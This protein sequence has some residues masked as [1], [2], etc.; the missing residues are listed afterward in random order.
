MLWF[1]WFGF[2]A[3]SA[4]AASETAV[5]AFLNTNTASAS[6]MLA[7]ILVDT[8]NGKKITAL[9]ACIGAVVGLV[10]ITPAAGYVTVGQ[11]LLI[12]SAASAISNFAVSLRSRFT[13]DDTLDVFPCH[14]I[15]G[16]VG[17]IATGIFAND[18]GL[19][20]GH[21]TTFLFHLLA[22]VLV[23]AFALGGSLVLY[24]VTDLIIPMRVSAHDEE[25]GLDVSQ[26]GETF[27]EAD[28]VPGEK[29]YATE[30]V[31]GLSLA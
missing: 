15:G 8:V 10:A 23:T 1:G 30:G 14:G 26:H 16:M 22:L 21:T 28:T 9:G 7:W 27:D 12:G 6:A 31:G 13:L 3:G 25:V 17:M 24:K 11:S 4:L 20:H 5:Q 19:I 29:P 18:V 2:N